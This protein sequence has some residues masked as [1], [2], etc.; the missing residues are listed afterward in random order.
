[1][2]PQKFNPLNSF[3]QQTPRRMSGPL[4][5][6]ARRRAGKAGR[7]ARVSAPL[8]PSPPSAPDRC[9]KTGLA[10]TPPSAQVTSSFLLCEIHENW[11]SG[12]CVTT[13]V[14]F[15]FFAWQWM[16]P[17]PNGPRGACVP[18]RAVAV[19]VTALARAGRP[20]TEESPARVLPDRTSFATLPCAPVRCLPP[21]N[22]ISP[23]TLHSCKNV[24]SR[25]RP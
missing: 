20:R 23:F 22:V 3:A 19:T 2:P 1:M 21:K 7:A 16:A 9:V 4:G 12:P 15:F 5:A 14:D 10:T 13:L 17:G 24:E 8:P 25:P 6:P 11:S 18:P